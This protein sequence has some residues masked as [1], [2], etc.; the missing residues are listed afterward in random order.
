[1]DASEHPPLTDR[2]ARAVI[3]AAEQLGFEREPDLYEAWYHL[4]LHADAG[5]ATQYLRER[6]PDAL[7][8]AL[9]AD[10]VIPAE[11]AAIR[12]TDSGRFSLADADRMI[13][14][15]AERGFTPPS[16]DLPLLPQVQ[17]FERARAA[18]AFMWER[19]P[20]DLTELFGEVVR[21]APLPPTARNPRDIW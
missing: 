12:I 17:T 14:V 16:S 2:Q 10:E 6:D 13:E 19:H 4:D 9:V 3:V 18:L 20:L 21:L 8:R 5:Y 15:A 1:M 7:A 11:D